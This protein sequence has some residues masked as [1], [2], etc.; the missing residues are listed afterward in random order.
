MREAGHLISEEK[1]E[2]TLNADLIKKVKG[3]KVAP[4]GWTKGNPES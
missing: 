3:G 2:G 1:G 4:E